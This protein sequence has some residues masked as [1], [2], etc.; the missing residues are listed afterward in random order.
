[1]KDKIEI[2]NLVPKFLDFYKRAVGCDEETRFELWKKH[3]GFAAVPPGEEGAQ[4]AKQ[5]LLAAWERYEKVIP[6]LEQWSPDSEKIQ[7]YLSKIKDALE[8]KEPVEVVL[9]F[10]VG[11]FDGNAFAA[12]YGE[13]RIA[14][15]LP[16]EEGENHI[17]IAHELTHLVHGKITN[18]T[19]SWERPVASL[20][21][22]EGLATQLSRHLVPGYKDEDYLACQASWLQECYK[23]E[24]Q[25]LQGI[26][27]Y[28]R[29]CSAE[30]ILQFTM[31]TGTTG[32]QREGYFAGWKLIGDMRKNGWSFSDIARIREEEMG[33]VLEKG[34]Y[35]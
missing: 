5:Q 34:S 25:I 8:Y 7:Q 11:A 20:I 2:I 27:P 35:E 3:Y 4:L 12:P 32:K 31:G 19:M 9:L 14:I 16:T 26:K 17:V 23:D 15:C 28:L 21:V 18:L 30:R 1:M 24:K 13:N 10:F 33:N 22:Q 29:E 6:H